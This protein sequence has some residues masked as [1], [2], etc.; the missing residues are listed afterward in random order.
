VTANGTILTFYSYKGGVGRTLALANVGALL[1]T[2]GYRVLCLDWDLEAPGLH[3][4][5]ERWIH[6][7]G[8]P[9]LVELIAEPDADW[10]QHLMEVTLPEAPGPL[11]L[12]PAGRFDDTYVRRM[13]DIDWA[14]LYQ[15]HELGARL[16][17]LREEWKKEYDFVLID[18]RTGVTDIGGICTIQM[19]D[20]LVLLFTANYQSLNGAL[21]VAKRAAEQRN[22]LPYDRAGVSCVPVPT[23]FEGR[24]QLE[25]AK[26]WLEI[27]AD[28]L[29]PLYRDWA[30]RDVL[31]RQLLDLIRIP[32]VAFWSFG[33]KMPVLDE[34]TKDPESIGFAMET[35]TALLAH[36][37]AGTDL[38]VRNRDQ[39]VAAAHRTDTSDADFDSDVFIS[40]NRRDENF[41]RALRVGLGEKGL[42]TSGE[43]KDI[44]GAQSFQAGLQ[45][46][47]ERSRSF[48]FIAG[49]RSSSTWQD[50]ELELALRQLYE[51]RHRARRVV[52]LLREGVMP[53]EIP[54][55]LQ[56][57]QFV[58]SKGDEPSGELL[59][60]L[61][62]LLR[63]GPSS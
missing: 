34:G 52:P 63:P 51:D 36:R 40:Y 33:E 48:L 39:F 55:P 11:H 61:A 3:L 8:S 46:S 45:R 37:L 50:I 43:I 10:R 32:Y 7:S 35:L 60:E 17:S 49:P 62:A 1:S 22:R 23:R 38:L 4:Y 44:A 57:F 29:E 59:D 25:L 53:G 47:I 30:D 41:V 16:E 14:L 28:R 54:P 56:S 6:D 58:R 26:E 9:G 31:P 12:L 20:Q 19:P 27:F 2:W 5:F 18:S 42:K 24:V 21:E 15:E 13:Q